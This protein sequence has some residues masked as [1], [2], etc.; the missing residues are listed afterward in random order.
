MDFRKPAVRTLSR[1]GTRLAPGHRVRGVRTRWVDAGPVRARVYEPLSSGAPHPGLLWLHGGGL[2][3]GDPRQ[4]DRLCAGAAAELGITVVS[5]RYRLAPEHP[6]PA[7]LDDA[8]AAWRWTQEHTAE[9]GVEPGA[10]ALGGESAGGGLAACLAQLLRDTSED[11]PVA[12]WLF[13]PMLDDRTA[14]R[15]HLDELDHPVWNNTA[16]RFGWRAYLGV[17]PGIE[18]LRD[19]AAAARRLDLSGLPPTWICAG[20]IELF[21]D[22]VV[23]YATRLG[24]AGVDTTLDIVPGGAH[25]FENWAATT[26][27]ATSLVARARAWLGAVLDR[28]RAT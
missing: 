9:L 12:Q 2:V 10:V 24:D 21:H 27:L 5:P 6:F 3:I 4:D 28:A 20:D 22:E 14:A 18:D 1:W 26:P 16:N 7:A 8:A 15:R 11:R 19:Y 23:D 13:A 25:G 17:E